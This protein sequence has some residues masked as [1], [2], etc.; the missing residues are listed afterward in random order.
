MIP[1]LFVHVG[2]AAGRSAQEQQ[3][4]HAD[5]SEQDGHSDSERQRHQLGAEHRRRGR[6]LLSGM[7]RDRCRRCAL[8]RRYELALRCWFRSLSAAEL[9]EVDGEHGDETEQ[10]KV[11]RESGHVVRG[12]G[13]EF[14]GQMSG[15]EGER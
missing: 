13:L 2:G 5:G 1:L 11:A 14:C 12:C 15:G 10:Q 8:A 6:V 3:R 4:R 7:F 9:D